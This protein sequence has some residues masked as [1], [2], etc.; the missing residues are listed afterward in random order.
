MNDDAKYFFFLS[1]F[2]GFI[3]FYGFSLFL[4]HDFLESLIYGSIGSLFLSFSWRMLLS[5]ALKK[6][7]CSRESVIGNGVDESE[8]LKKGS[9]QSPD[10]SN[11]S[12]EIVNS[13]T[14]AN[15]EAS[16]TRKNITSVGNSLRK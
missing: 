14:R 11:S 9:S 15:M 16:S 2:I 6:L 1:G 13:T 7:Q 12:S 3:F 10:G 4:N 5:S 8:I